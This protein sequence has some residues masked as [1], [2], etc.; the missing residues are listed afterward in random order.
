MGT[1]I[2]LGVWGGFHHHLDFLVDVVEQVLEDTKESFNLILVVGD[3]LKSFI[4]SN[5]LK[6]NLTGWKH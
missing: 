6:F 5:K 3:L 4:G 1:G 2:K